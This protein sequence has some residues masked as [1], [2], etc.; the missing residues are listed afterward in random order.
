MQVH[1]RMVR[2][3]RTPVLW[4]EAETFGSPHHR[5]CG[6]R[7]LLVAPLFRQTDLRAMFAYL[8]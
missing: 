4:T 6:R 5:A 3:E 7:S 1:V 8:E 2:P